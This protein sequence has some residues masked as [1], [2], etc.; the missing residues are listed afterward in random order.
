M[1]FNSNK[2]TEKEVLTESRKENI[3]FSIEGVDIEALDTI[4]GKTL[5]DLELQITTA[6]CL[7]NDK[8]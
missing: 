1:K 2:N 4:T 7:K 8:K 5:E 6:V 3:V